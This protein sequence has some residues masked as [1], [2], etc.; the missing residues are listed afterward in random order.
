MPSSMM[1]C[2]RVGSLEGES[3]DSANQQPEKD[4]AQRPGEPNDDRRD[5]HEE[6]PTAFEELAGVGGGRSQG[7]AFDK[8]A[9][10]SISGSILVVG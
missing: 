8:S 6:M 4:R 10:R 5:D 9:Q 7:A 2:H 3:L 1:H